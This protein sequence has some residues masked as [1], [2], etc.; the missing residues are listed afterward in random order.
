M[1]R[2][3]LVSCFAGVASWYDH[4]SLLE[5]AQNDSLVEIDYRQTYFCIY[6]LNMVKDSSLQRSKRLRDAL[7]EQGLPFAIIPGRTGTGT[8]KV[9]CLPQ[10]MHPGYIGNWRS[11]VAAWRRGHSHCGGDFIVVLENDAIVPFG[12]VRHLRKL[13]RSMKLHG[14]QVA[15]L[16]GRHGDHAQE[17][18]GAASYGIGAMA[19]ST[20]VLPLMISQF[21]DGADALW[22]NY[23]SKRRP[24]VDHEICLTDWY[25]GNVVAASNIA[26]VRFPLFDHPAAAISEIH[27][28]G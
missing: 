28:I 13:F 7:F 23:T 18:V 14:R 4:M 2:F 21:T 11:H 24:L 20:A 19:L 25:M 9:E 10:R 15:W 6:V 27:E 1:R 3:L 5:R 17:Q 8:W 26:A 12:V 16:D 22:R